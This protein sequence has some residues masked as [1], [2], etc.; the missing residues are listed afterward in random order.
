MAS[1]RSPTDVNEAHTTEGAAPRRDRRKIPALGLVAGI[2]LIGAVATLW[3]RV[4]DPFNPYRPGTAHRIV[5][6]HEQPGCMNRWG[7]GVAL[8]VRYYHWG[9][10][11]APADWEPGPVEGTLTILHDWGSTGTDAVFEA[12]GQKVNLTGGSNSGVHWDDLSCTVR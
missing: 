8:G 10:G 1:R 7:V 12:N 4:A 2:L 3:V 9:R 6:V 5:L 11:A